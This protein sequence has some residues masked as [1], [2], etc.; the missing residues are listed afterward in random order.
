MK[1]Q[2]ENFIQS[3]IKNVSHIYRVSRVSVLSPDLARLARRPL[4]CPDA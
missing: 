3:I 1:F 2:T 4:Q